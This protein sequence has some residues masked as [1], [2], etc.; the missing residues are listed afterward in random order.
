[1]SPVTFNDISTC[2]AFINNYWKNFSIK[3]KI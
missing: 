2:D 3:S 1:M